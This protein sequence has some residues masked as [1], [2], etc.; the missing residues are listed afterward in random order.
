MNFKIKADKRKLLFLTAGGVIIAVVIA[1][2]LFLGLGSRLK[3]IKNEIKLGE[4]RLIKGLR[5]QKRKDEILSDYNRYK[6]YLKEKEREDRE[7]IENLLK[8]IERISSE[9]R[10]SVLNLSP[11]SLNEQSKGKKDYKADLRFE[12]KN[13]QLLFFLYKIQESKFLIKLDK[14]SIRPK[15]EA[16]SVLKVDTTVSIIDL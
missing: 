7:I 3:K 10:V 11:Q 15:D 6:G 14:L 8:E 5:M 13:Q 2:F 1:N 9:S 16:A 12:C 4:V